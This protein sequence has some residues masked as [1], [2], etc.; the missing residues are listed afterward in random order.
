MLELETESNNLSI[1][2]SIIL[3]SFIYFAFNFPPTSTW[4]FKTNRIINTSL[5]LEN[6]VSENCDRI[7][8]LQRMCAICESSDVVYL[9]M[10]ISG[11]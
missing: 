4:H 3:A 5:E 6:C 9:A 10:H 2:L 8:I 1:V 7:A 11:E